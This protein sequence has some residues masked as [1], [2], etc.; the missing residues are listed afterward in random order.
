MTVRAT[1][2]ERGKLMEAIAFCGMLLGAFPGAAHAECSC[3]ATC[4]DCVSCPRQ[5]ETIGS[6]GACYNTTNLKS[7][8]LCSFIGTMAPASAR[9]TL[10]GTRQDT[11]TEPALPSILPGTRPDVLRPDLMVNRRKMRSPTRG[12]LEL[13]DIRAGARPEWLEQSAAGILPGTRPDPVSP[14]TPGIL[15]GTVPDTLQPVFAINVQ[16]PPLWWVLSRTRPDQ[17]RPG[18]GGVVSDTP[19]PPPAPEE[20]PKLP[21]SADSKQ[22]SN[23][24]PSTSRPHRNPGETREILPG[25]RWGWDASRPRAARTGK[26][27]NR[28]KLQRSAPTAHQ[29]R[30][31]R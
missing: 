1:P 27:R 8:V 28:E 21:G 3:S 26:A 18:I 16:P 22:P 29:S 23:S 11:V 19:Q 17:I 30:V 6:C 25:T 24:A 7:S 9:P 13:P 2:Q 10:P 31:P 5:Y 14:A 12:H 15:P 4:G 20:D